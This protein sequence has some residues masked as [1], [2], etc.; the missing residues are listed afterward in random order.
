MDYGNCSRLEQRICDASQFGYLKVLFLFSNPFSVPNETLLFLSR[1]NSHQTGS[2]VLINSRK[3]H[4]PLQWFSNVVVVSANNFTKSSFIY[5]QLQFCSNIRFVLVHVPFDLL[6]QQAEKLGVEMRVRSDFRPV[7]F[8]P[9]YVR[10]LQFIFLQLCNIQ[11]FWTLP[12][13][14]IHARCI[15]GLVDLGSIPFCNVY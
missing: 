5:R 1:R 12:T 2:Y 11:H 13:A 9:I 14:A 7:C 10:S 15:D 3:I 4:D 6:C 8:H